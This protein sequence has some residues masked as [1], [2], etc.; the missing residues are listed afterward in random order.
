MDPAG[1]S[2]TLPAVSWILAL[3]S[4]WTWRMAWR[5]SRTAR[6]RLILFSSS[7]SLGIAALVSLACLGRNLR[8]A[9]ESQSKA[10]LGADLVFTRREPFSPEDRALIR[11]L[12]ARMGEEI[13]FSTMLGLDSGARL[14]NARAISGGFPFYGTLETEPP[15]AAEEF[16]S[17]LGILVDQ[18]VLLQFGAKPGD[19]A[20]LGQSHFRILGA[21][22]R[23][24]G[25]TVAFASIA[26]RVYLPGPSL[27]ATGLLQSG[28]LA[29][30]RLTLAF[31]S[32]LDAQHRLSPIEKDLERRRIE[33]DTVEKRQRD[34][35]ESLTNLRRFLN[36]VGLV[37][38]LLGCI[39]IASALQV[40]V[41]QKRTH[42]GLLRCLGA[43]MPRVFAI[44]LAQGITLGAVGSLLGAAIGA[45]AARFL[46]TL[47][48]S[49]IPFALG[50]S[51]AW[52]ETLG[53]VAAG[54]ILCLLFTLLPL[55]ELRGISPLAVLR[56][57]TTNSS[58]VNRPRAVVFAC[59]AIGLQAF[60]LAQ[61]RSALE[62]LSIAG[63]LA[64]AFAVLTGVASVLAWTAKRVVPRRLPFVVRQ[65]IANLHRP[66]NRTTLLILSLG[67][68]TFL[69]LTL[70]LVR[71]SLL[72][73]LFPPSAGNK[74]NT[75]LFD[76]QPDQRDGVL[77]LLARHQLPALEQAPIVTMRIASL[78]GVPVAAL[79]PKSQDRAAKEAIPDWALR[80][81]YRSTWRDRMIDTETLTAGL[82]NPRVEGAS[83]EQ[84]PVPVSLEEGIARDL[85]L[86]VGDRITFDVQGIELP[87]RVGSLRHVDWRQ[88]RPN[89]FIV[90]PA[91]ALEDA[92]AQYIVATRTESALAVAS[93]QR[94]LLAAFPNVS[95]V[96]LT[97]VLQTLD[98][99]VSRVGFV[100]RF[101]ALF[102]VLTGL[103][104]LGGTIVTGRWQRMQEAVLLR[105]LGA[106]R[107]QIRG[108]LIAEYAALGSL[109]AASGVGLAAAGSAALSQFAFHAPPVLPGIPLAVA[110]LAVTLLTV[111][112]GV[113]GSRGIAD[114][115]P[116]E[117]LR[118]EA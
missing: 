114:E 36:L 110:W 75:I 49:L 38:L 47:V 67:L 70:H 77:Q 81:E 101:M 85:R 42:A 113:L 106:S 55:L 10:L 86:K 82:W 64:G 61:S 54:F 84:N 51:M 95:T 71:V 21:L 58:R 40:H 118:R 60:L 30:Y 111:G 83:S 5:E 27:G 107:G 116:L 74:P 37:A 28:S 29:R 25:D 39:G 97:L 44:Y 68:G 32:G 19:T 108:I 3:F 26:P 59:I 76:I 69:L 72:A 9:I 98:R 45:A 31:D 11:P 41:S 20:R 91:G 63:G 18:T 109:A 78:N 100:V 73:Q 112:I 57:D 56:V 62:G 48:G 43:P 1:F 92:P 24:P 46:P 13:S 33:V 80:R 65:G 87:C 115:P 52:T 8:D 117:V 23:A 6:R 17:G 35:G 79:N 93:F 12:G 34:L 7:I 53:A 105:T 16:R 102:T 99:I 94:D 15:S 96:D 104:V 103:V 2:S 4:R 89:F 90:F 50:S 22:L 66:K 14:V 88:V